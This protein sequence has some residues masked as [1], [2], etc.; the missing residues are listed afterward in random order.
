MSSEETEVHEGLRGEE[1]KCVWSLNERDV[2][3][4][5]INEGESS[6]VEEKISGAFVPPVC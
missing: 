6:K 4:I 1:E 2:K 3:V 5:L